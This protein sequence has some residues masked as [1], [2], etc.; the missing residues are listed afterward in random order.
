MTALESIPFRGLYQYDDYLAVDLT[1]LK[2]RLRT[3]RKIEVLLP[4]RV[5]IELTSDRVNA[6]RRMML[7][8]DAP[9]MVMG[10]AGGQAEG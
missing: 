3:A 4:S 1:P 5:A 8:I 9:Q 2:E 6:V 10:L 7:L